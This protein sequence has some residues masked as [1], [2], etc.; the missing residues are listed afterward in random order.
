MKTVLSEEWK[1]DSLERYRNESDLD[2]MRNKLHSLMQKP[3]QKTNECIGKLKAPYGSIY[4]KEKTASRTA[5]EKDIALISDI[6]QIRDDQ[7]EKILL[8]NS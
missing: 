6:E 3:K 5:N 4:G 1:Q 7:K 2:K 8:T